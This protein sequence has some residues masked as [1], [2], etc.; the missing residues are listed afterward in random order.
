MK[1]SEK[2]WEQDGKLIIKETHDLEPTFNQVQQMK[3]PGWT[4]WGENRHIMR[5]PLPLIEQW[6]QEAGVRFDD[7]EAVKEVMKKKILSGE[8]NDLRPWEGT[9]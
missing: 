7:H 2:Y 5:L 6:I 1:I 4:G 9:Y 3:S 8:Y